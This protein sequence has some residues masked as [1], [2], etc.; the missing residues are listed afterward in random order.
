[1]SIYT[2]IGMYTSTAEVYADH[3]EA[4]GPHE[5]MLLAA[6]VC[7]DRYD[8]DILGAFPGEHAITTA[9]EDS[10]KAACAVDLVGEEDEEDDTLCDVCCIRLEQGN[11]DNYLGCCQVC[12]DR[13]N[14][15][16]D[17]KDI[18]WEAAVND[19]LL[20]KDEEE[21]DEDRD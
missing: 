17:K 15:W 8:L 4:A 10:G 19:V 18:D 1:M 12:A 5:A 9:C 16:A 3:I 14:E 2:V 20:G 13:V 21:D 7:L 11:G 6:A